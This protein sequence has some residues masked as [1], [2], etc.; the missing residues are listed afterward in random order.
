MA[1]VVHDRSTSRLF[2]VAAA[3]AITIGLITSR[4]LPDAT[5]QPR[6]VSFAAGLALMCSAI[7]LSASARAEL[8]RFHRNALTVHPE[9]HV[10]DSG[11]YAVVRHPLY[12]ATVLAFAGIGLTL[13]NWGSLTAAGLPTAALIHRIGV[14]EAMLDDHLGEKYETYRASTQRLVPGLW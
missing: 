14:E 6:A 5:I 2:D 3:S 4:R 13:G 11:P 7:G 12:A 10:V 1:D 8:G 9:H